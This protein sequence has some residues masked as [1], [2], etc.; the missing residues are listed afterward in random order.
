LIHL[1]LFFSL[2]LFFTACDKPQYHTAYHE[3]IPEYNQ[4]KIRPVYDAEK[5]RY[6]LKNSK[7]QYPNSDFVVVDYNQFEGKK[8]PFFFLDENES[9]VFLCDKNS[10]D[11]VMRSELHQGSEAKFEN[12]NFWS[13]EQN[14][15]IEGVVKLYFAP[16][17]RNYTWFQIHAA[18]PFSY[19]PIRMTVL[20]NK[21]G[22]EDHI[23]AVIMPSTD[24]NATRVWFDLGKRE[25]KFFTFKL[26]VHNYN[27]DI[28]FDEKEVFHHDMSYWKS[29]TINGENVA[30]RNYFKV[31]SYITR[32]EDRGKAVVVFHELQYHLSTP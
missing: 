18:H 31:G 30:L 6:V 4:S 11:D 8:F 26:I 23:W 12:Q 27:L 21:D 16:T 3:P 9:M 17:L 29:V 15:S 28:Y 1:T 7:L 5:F 22:I 20:Q 13:F 32:H 25:D 2:L 24:I 14:N 19:P 10:T